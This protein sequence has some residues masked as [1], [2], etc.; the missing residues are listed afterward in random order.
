M[1]TLFDFNQYDPETALLIAQLQ[2]EDTSR[3]PK[4][5]KERAD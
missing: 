1:A 5:A 2:L 4:G 3:Y